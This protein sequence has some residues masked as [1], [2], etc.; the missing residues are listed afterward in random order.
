MDLPLYTIKQS[1][2][3]ILIP[4]A[5]KLLGL[6][7]MLYLG[8]L[9]NL[10][11]MKKSIPSYINYLIIAVIFILVLIE[12]LLTHNK[13]LKNKYYFFPGRIELRGKEPKTLDFRYITSVSIS[14]NLLD[15][16]LRTGTINIEPDFK[17]GPISN[18]NQV[19]AY[20]QKLVQQVAHPLL[21]G[22]QQQLKQQL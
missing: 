14:Q 8:V 5:L 17:I 22:Q 6:A 9:L 20:L 12:A 15:K 1:V 3:R 2:L 11:M 4:K 19:Y 16:I 13:I 21:Q 10:Y 7:I 18:C